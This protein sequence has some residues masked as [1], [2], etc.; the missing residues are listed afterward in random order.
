[1]IY[2]LSMGV[3]VTWLMYLKFKNYEAWTS[4]DRSHKLLTFLILVLIWVGFI[5]PF[6]DDVITDAIKKYKGQK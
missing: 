3:I 1:M 4:M 5:I 2:Y 6:L